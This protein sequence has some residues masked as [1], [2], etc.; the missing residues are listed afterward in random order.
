M[1]LIRA[2]V[3]IESGAQH[4]LEVFGKRTSVADNRHAVLTL[5]QLGILADFNLLMFNP[6][7]TLD[8]VED[9]LAF[10]ED[11]AGDGSVP[12]SIARMEVYSGT[13]FQ[14]R[15]A[16]EGRLLGDYRAWD[17]ADRRPGG[18]S[19]CSGRCWPRCTGATTIP[20][21]SPRP[22]SRPTTSC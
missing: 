9:D 5:Q 18:A 10:V 16:S 3:G 8:D 11:L 7:T 1:G 2:Y 12:V 21:G 15:L 17:Y 22:P 20:R 4:A 6:Y 19:C 14:S 13:P